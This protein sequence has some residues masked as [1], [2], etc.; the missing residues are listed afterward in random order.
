MFKPGQVIPQGYTVCV[1]SWEN[2]ADHPQ[3][4]YLFGLTK[5]EVNDVLKFT[6][7]F[8]HAMDDLCNDD[9]TDEAIIELL[10]VKYHESE[11]SAHFINKFFGLDTPPN[12]NCTDEEY[13]NYIK[14]QSDH[15][16]IMENLHSFLGTPVDYDYDFARV[17]SNVSV[18]FF[19]EGFTVPEMP[20]V[21]VKFDGSWQARSKGVDH[22][23]I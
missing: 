22:W 4:N 3:Q 13:Y 18:Y 1:S 19:P 2:D 21:L 9:I 11:I 16:D 5:D 8:T 7:L 15:D 10:M 17:V 12:E 20:P 23:K 6:S 14:E